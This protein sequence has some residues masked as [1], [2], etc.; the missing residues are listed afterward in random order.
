MLYSSPPSEE[1]LEYLVR[2]RM[3]V[4]AI[5]RLWLFVVSSCNTI[6][7]NWLCVEK[8]IHIIVQ[9][10]IDIKEKINSQCYLSV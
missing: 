3:Y 5:S 2:S 8:L 9:H 1:P 4:V 6:V 10:K 7:G